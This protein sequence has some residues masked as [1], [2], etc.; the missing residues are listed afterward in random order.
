MEEAMHQVL[1][2]VARAEGRRPAVCL[3]L[4]AVERSN[5]PATNQYTRFCGAIGEAL[6]RRKP[7]TLGRA[8]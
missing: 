7:G 4:T 8:R 5:Y 1:I 6:P 3:Y 2:C